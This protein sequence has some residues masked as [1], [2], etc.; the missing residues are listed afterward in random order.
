MPLVIVNVLTPLFE[1]STPFLAMTTA[2][3][4]QKHKSLDFNK[5]CTTLPRLLGK[6]NI[7]TYST[8]LK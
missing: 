8:H 2:I 3:F 6:T 5:T 7:I 4:K 1:I